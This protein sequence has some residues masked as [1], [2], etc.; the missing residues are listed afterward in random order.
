MGNPNTG[1]SFIT[2]Y[3]GEDVVAGA[4]LGRQ[5]ESGLAFGIHSH[6]EV[7]TANT[8][9]LERGYLSKLGCVADVAK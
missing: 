1:E 2:A 9:I 5:G 6:F 4:L 8:P 7:R 3:L